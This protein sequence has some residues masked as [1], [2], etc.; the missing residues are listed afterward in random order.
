MTL[1]KKHNKE[2]HKAKTHKSDII[3]LEQAFSEI[4]GYSI[5]EAHQNIM[6]ERFEKKEKP[7]I[8]CWTGTNSEI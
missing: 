8:D 3:P 5:P 6:M 2:Y 1:S 7:P 4:E